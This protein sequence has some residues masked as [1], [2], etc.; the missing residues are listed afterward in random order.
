M[1][2][3]VGS[4]SVR[5]TGTTSELKQ[6]ATEKKLLYEQLNNQFSNLL[7]ALRIYHQQLSILNKELQLARQVEAGEDKKFYEGDSTLFLVNQREQTTTQVQ[8][9]LISAGVN[10]QETS[11]LVRFF[12]STLSR[13]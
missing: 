3:S 2:F 5:L 10:L 7:I 9:N 4:A 12:V 13:G 6:I 1:K 8:L 11:S